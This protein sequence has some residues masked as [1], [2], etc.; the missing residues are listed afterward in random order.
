VSRAHSRLVSA[1]FKKTAGATD[2]SQATSE[3]LRSHPRDV[4]RF[5]DIIEELQGEEAPGFAA[6]SV[7]TREL[8]ALADRLS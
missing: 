4:E 1:A 3:L 7:T 2:P 8:S 6:I 5:M